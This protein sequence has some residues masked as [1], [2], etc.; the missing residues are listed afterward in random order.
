VNKKRMKRKRRRLSKKE[1]ERREREEAERKAKARAESE[2]RQEKI[3]V[4]MQELKESPD[5]ARELAKDQLGQALLDLV[6]LQ[7]HEIEYLRPFWELVQKISKRFP[8]E[9]RNL[10]EAN[11]F[12][13]FKELCAEF[14]KLLPSALQK[15]SSKQKHE[16]KR[17]RQFAAGAAG[18]IEW[19]F[20]GAREQLCQM[21]PLLR[22]TPSLTLMPPSCLDNILAGDPVNMDRLEKLFWMHRNR[23]GKLQ[24]VKRGREK[25]Y[26]YRAVLT[27]MDKLLGEPSRR[28]AR[29]IRLRTWLPALD[30]RT[31]VLSGIEARIKSLLTP[32][33]IKAEF[34]G[35][36]RRHLPHSAKK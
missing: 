22:L 16:A 31:R 4:L 33:Q 29:G 11:A 14:E 27:I 35:V 2:D 10:S 26:G 3:K 9:W 7:K 23:F 30:L 20:G 17:R 24:G 21:D 12:A 18:L 6:G 13:E 36:I 1:L 15:P 28:K 32:E 19:E 34:L 8:S 25:L 5:A